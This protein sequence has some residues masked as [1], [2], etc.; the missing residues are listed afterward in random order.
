M[1]NLLRKIAP[2]GFCVFALAGTAATSIAPASAQDANS[3]DC[4]IA[5][6]CSPSDPNFHGYSNPAFHGRSTPAFQDFS[7]V[8][9]S[10]ADQPTAGGSQA[11]WNSHDCR[12]YGICPWSPGQSR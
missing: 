3:R 11:D 5:G 10:V 9:G 2:I 1:M 12:H 4:K 8:F 6:I 7:N